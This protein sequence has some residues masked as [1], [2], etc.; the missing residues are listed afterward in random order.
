MGSL[1]SASALQTGFLNISTEGN[2]VCVIRLSAVCK[3]KTTQHFSALIFVVWKM[4]QANF[5]LIY[6]IQAGLELL[7]LLSPPTQ[8]WDCGCVPPHRMINTQ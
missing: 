1:L 2:E 5:L 7:I 6:V 8:C 3:A 4:S